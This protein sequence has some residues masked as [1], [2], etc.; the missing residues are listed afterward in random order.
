MKKIIILL[1]ASLTIVI[2]GCGKKSVDD[3][4]SMMDKSDSKQDA[5]TQNSDSDKYKK[6]I[7]SEGYKECVNDVPEL[8]EQGNAVTVTLQGNKKITL[9]MRVDDVLACD[10]ISALKQ[11]TSENAYNNLVNYALYK[12][13]ND[14]IAEDGSITESERGIKRKAVCVKLGVTNDDNDSYILG[15]AAF[16]LYDLRDIKE[17]GTFQYQRLQGRFA[18]TDVPDGWEYKS[19]DKV[20]LQPHEEREIVLIFFVETEWID[21]GV[22][23]NDN[24]NYT[25][26]DIKT[27]GSSFNNIYMTT[28]FAE[29]SGVNVKQGFAAN[30][31]LLQLN[32]M[33][34]D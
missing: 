19:S 27:G 1:M 20:T 11:L 29:V 18:Y 34:T 23:L 22:R 12:D 30:K 24:G 33:D 2:T 10:N 31:A 6:N 15:P 3:I 14:F 8:I 5:A 7:K 16:M 9:T 4:Y 26:V 17:D 25:Y 28:S 32:I 21:S 13:N